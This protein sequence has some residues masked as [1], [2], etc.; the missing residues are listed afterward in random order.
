MS[1]GKFG[2]GAIWVRGMCL[3]ATSEI[4][5]SIDLSRRPRLANLVGQGLDKFLS[6]C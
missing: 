3:I 5:D 2:T 4:H 6:S 1:S